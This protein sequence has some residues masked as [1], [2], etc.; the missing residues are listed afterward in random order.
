M[1]TNDIYFTGLSDET[2]DA[3][4]D[5][6]LKA[7]TDKEVLEA[8]RAV[9]LHFTRE[10]VAHEYAKAE[11]E[12]YALGLALDAVDKC[13]DTDAYDMIDAAY[14]RAEKLAFFLAENLDDRND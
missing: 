8:H 5:Y 13:T 12:R 11:R 4:L 14:D 9:D 2:R 1:R 3:C 6:A 10:D 7:T